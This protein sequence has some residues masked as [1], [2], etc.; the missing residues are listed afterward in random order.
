MRLPRHS[1]DDADGLK[2][3]L[4]SLVFFLSRLFAIGFPAGSFL[5]S[6]CCPSRHESAGF[7]VYIAMLHFQH[8]AAD[9][10]RRYRAGIDGLL[11]VAILLGKAVL[12]ARNQ[13]PPPP[14]GRKMPALSSIRRALRTQSHGMPRSAAITAPL[15]EPANSRYFAIRCL[16]LSR[17][18]MATF[19]SGPRRRYE[20]NRKA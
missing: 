20:N 12:I 13:M 7:V 17:S 4:A 3:D 8:A 5:E 1:H 10:F 2:Y 15:A 19:R 9:F 6:L 18:A 11:L 14:P 16:M